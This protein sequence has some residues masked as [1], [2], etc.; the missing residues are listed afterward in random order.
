MTLFD[1]FAHRRLDAG[2]RLRQDA[3]VDEI[4]NRWTPTSTRD[5]LLHRRAQ[6]VHWW[7]R[8]FGG[9]PTLLQVSVGAAFV[10]LGPAL[11]IVAP[12]PNTD[13]YA[14]P[15]PNWARFV[16]IIGL[17][18]LA[19]ESFLSP[20][21]VRTRRAVAIAIAPIPVVEFWLLLAYPFP[22][23]PQWPPRAAWAVVGTAIALL[24]AAGKRRHRATLRAALVLAVA[25]TGALAVSEVV[26]VV[27]YFV[28]GDPL[29]ST[30]SAVT[31]VGATLIAASLL[32][33]RVE[34]A[35]DARSPASSAERRAL[36]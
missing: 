22:A 28:D 26:R 2:E 30:A 32:R 7:M 29:L 20:R 10:A 12:A 6:V 3:F 14:V 36:R 19:A 27:V 9:G 13:A 23:W 31:A 18:V 33:A 35:P 17:V 4:T 16:V 5:R 34:F 24:I 1:A 25:G 8:L 15:I 11:R 21:R